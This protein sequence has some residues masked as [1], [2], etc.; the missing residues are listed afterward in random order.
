MNKEENPTKALSDQMPS[1][2]EKSSE[3]AETNQKALKTTP[4]DTTSKSNYGPTS[5]STGDSSA[6]PSAKTNKFVAFVKSK[7]GVCI[8]AAILIV[9]VLTL[10]FIK[11]YTNEKNYEK[12][13][14]EFVLE[15]GKSIVASAIICDDIRKVWRDYIFDE[16]EYFNSSTG[17]FTKYSYYS[18]NN[19]EH[20]SD[21]SEAVDR[22][23]SWNKDHLSSDITEPYHTAKRLYKEMTP[24]PGKYK[25]IH[26]YV[27]QMFKAMERLQEL[28][29]NPTGNLSSYSTDC[30]TTANDY[31][32]ALSDLSNESDLDFSKIDDD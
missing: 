13:L 26:T 16:K 25:E 17:Q 31:T 8:L 6:N 2:T 18:S 3:S 11:K 10:V 14:K 21:F 23:I 12:N 9:G 5:D 1:E 28:S 29:E 24:P 4:V 7:A 15:S 20:C 30:N 22:K 27:K 19:G 32:S